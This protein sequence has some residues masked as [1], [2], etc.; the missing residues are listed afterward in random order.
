MITG[1]TGTGKSTFGMSV[2]LDQGILKCISTDTLRSVMRSFVTKDI[3][4]AL[5]R[6]SYEP[7]TED[8][9]D[10]PVKSWK[11]TCAVLQHCVDELVDE[12]IGRGASIV[13]EGAQLIP[14]ND[15][16]Q[17]WE[18]SG[19]VATGVVLQV[20]DEEA[21]KSL[22][23]RRGMTTGKGEERKLEEFKRIRAIHDEM[24]NLGREV[25]WCIIEQNL[26]PDPLEVVAS[27][28]W[29]GPR[30]ESF[31]TE[32]MTSRSER[33]SEQFWKPHQGKVEDTD[34]QEQSTNSSEP[35][36]GSR[37]PV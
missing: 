21:H 37:V 7:A 13:I 18:E 24:V 1:C 28:L 22:L 11:Q 9:S 33:R 2:A 35:K 34:Q 3:S 30:I 29:R 36:R 26:Q 4:P 15:L 14:C 12:M 19:G 5:H 20:P 17:R 6:S 27:Q 23:I 32:P 10:D 31:S 16:L 25:N 8:G